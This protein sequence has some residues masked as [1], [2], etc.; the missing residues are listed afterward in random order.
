MIFC[1]I[2]YAFV[3]YFSDNSPG[4]RSS[5]VGHHFAHPTN[6]F[7]RALHLSGLTPRLLTPQE[8]TTLPGEYGYGLTNL[9]PRPTAEQAELSS[10]EMRLAVEPLVRKFVDLRA[11][12]VCFVGKKIW[13]IFAGVAGK[14]AKLR[15]K[16]DAAEAKK[17][18]KEAA[19][20]REVQRE[21]LEAKVTMCTLEDGLV[22]LEPEAE[23]EAPGPITPRKDRPE[24][25]IELIS[26]T[27]STTPSRPATPSTP[28]SKA[29]AF[30]KPQPLRL[31]LPDDKNA[32]WTHTYFWVVPNTSGLERT[33]LSGTTEYFAALKTFV[34]TLKAGDPL[35]DTFT[36][37]TLDEVES[38]VASIA[39]A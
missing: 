7:W 23:G 33:P 6:K 35:P 27:P 31:L 28:K 19:V 29:F 9:V 24:P 8:D 30:D 34:A 21:V 37:F 4:Q 5:R 17:R 22:K 36:D 1:G 13:D 20:K 10:H 32:K 14:S 26:R 39:H 2:K 25:Y 38:I 16:A 12:V 11:G 18:A 3:K 15:E